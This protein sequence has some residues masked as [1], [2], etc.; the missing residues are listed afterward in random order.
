MSTQNIKITQNLK[1]QKNSIQQYHQF[2]FYFFR[3]KKKKYEIGNV[4]IL[5]KLR[6]EI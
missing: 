2:P 3:N 1:F 5:K 4:S 6:G